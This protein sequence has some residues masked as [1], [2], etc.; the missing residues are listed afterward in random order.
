MAL[1]ITKKE[2]GILFIAIA[3]NLLSL[4]ITKKIPPN[5]SPILTI[6]IFTGL[7]LFLLRLDG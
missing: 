1:K 4:E 7:G 6:L 5:L 3:A 2:I